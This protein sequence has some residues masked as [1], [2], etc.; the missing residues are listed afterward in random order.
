MPFPG[1]VTMKPSAAQAVPSLAKATS[2]PGSPAPFVSAV[3]STRVHVDPLSAEHHTT[4]AIADPLPRTPASKMLFFPAERS[5]AR[6]PI[7]GAARGGSRW[8]GES[9]VVA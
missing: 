6:G 2:V 1:F 3:G 5:A 4:D 7:I 8:R 9:S